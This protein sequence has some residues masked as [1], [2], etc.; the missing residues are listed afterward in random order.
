MKGALFLNY[1]IGTLI[2][3][4]IPDIGA[5][6]MAELEN[7]AWKDDRRFRI[8]SVDQGVFSFVDLFMHTPSKPRSSAGPP[9]KYLH[10]DDGKNISITGGPP[11]LPCSAQSCPALLPCC[12]RHLLRRSRFMLNPAAL[13]T[14]A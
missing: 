8:M 6:R 11:S 2:L 7:A 9:S 14:P 10:E 3:K 4:G 1:Y 13:Q 5:G 12:T